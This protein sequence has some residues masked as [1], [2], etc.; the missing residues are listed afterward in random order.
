[1]IHGRAKHAN[2]GHQGKAQGERKSRG[3]CTAWVTLRVRGGQCSNCTKRCTDELAKEWNNWKAQRWASHEKAHDN[4]QCSHPNQRCTVARG[5]ICP[6]GSPDCEGNACAQDDK[7]NDGADLQR[8][9]CG[10]FCRAHGFDWLYCA[11]T[12]SRRP[13]R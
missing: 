5:A 13:C 2:R 6:Q 8:T 10:G 7:A 12:P 1:R 9:T 4:T 3:R 11:C